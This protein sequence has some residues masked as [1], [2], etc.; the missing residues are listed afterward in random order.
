ME[1]DLEIDLSF[2]DK[3]IINYQ[4]HNNLQVN[5]EPNCNLKKLNVKI[6]I[7]SSY[8]DSFEKLLLE[9]NIFNPIFLKKDNNFMLQIGYNEFIP[10]N[11]DDSLDSKYSLEFTISVPKNIKY[12]INAF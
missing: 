5:V 6:K 1:Q 2:F 11:L 7:I 9:S 4:D 12:E 10:L 3:L 8:N